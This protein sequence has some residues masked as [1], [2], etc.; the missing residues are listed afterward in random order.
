[1][2]NLFQGDSNDIR[3][4]TKKEKDIKLIDQ[5]NNKNS[6]FYSLAKKVVV[7]GGANIDI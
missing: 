7:I 4:K 6:N 1:M 3:E 2:N 5:S